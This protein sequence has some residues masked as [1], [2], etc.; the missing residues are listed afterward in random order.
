MVVKI[1]RAAENMRLLRL[2]AKNYTFQTVPFA[3]RYLGGGRGPTSFLNEIDLLRRNGF[4]FFQVTAA[5][6]IHSFPDLSR[7]APQA[8]RTVHRNEPA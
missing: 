2:I 8:R 5:E 4:G 1:G 7:C 6:V 3:S